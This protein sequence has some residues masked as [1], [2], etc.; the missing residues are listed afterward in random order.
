VVLALPFSDTLAV[1]FGNE[2]VPAVP[3]PVMLVVVGIVAFVPSLE[4]VTACGE[5]VLAR[6]AVGA[7]LEMLNVCA[8]GTPVPIVD[9]VS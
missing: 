7:V 9:A 1:T 8:T 5:V 6:L 2:A 4:N 3:P